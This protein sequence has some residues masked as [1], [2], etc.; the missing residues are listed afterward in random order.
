MLLLFPSSSI[1]TPILCLGRKGTYGAAAGD[2]S[3]GISGGKSSGSID[4]T[5]CRGQSPVNSYVPPRCPRGRCGVCYKVTNRGGHKGSHIGGIGKSIIA[6]IIDN[7]P[8]VNARNFCK[9]KT[10]L[11]ERCG[12]RDTNQLDIDRKT[13]RALTGQGYGFNVRFFS[14][15]LS[16]KATRS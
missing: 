14:Y 5:L 15:E 12:S 8:S 3:P 4:L 7:C 2:I 10:S 6:R 1:L 9:T 16:G 13:Y 11:D